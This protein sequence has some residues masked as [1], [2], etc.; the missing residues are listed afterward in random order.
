M[1]PLAAGEHEPSDSRFMDLI[2]SGGVDYVQLDIV[3]QGGIPTFRRIV[4]EIAKQG[5]RFAFHSWG[6]SLEVL[7]AAHLGICWPDSVVEWL[8]FPCYSTAGFE[9]MYPFPLADE[10]LKEPLEIDGGDLI[11][12]NR[13]GLGVEVDERGDRE[14]PVDSRAMVL[15]QDR[16]S[17]ADLGGVRRSRTAV[18]GSIVMALTLRSVAAWEILDS[19][20]N[21]TVAVEATLSN[22]VSGQAQVPSGASTGRHEALELRDGD[23]GWY[24]GKGVRR[25]VSNAATEIPLG[26]AVEPLSEFEALMLRADGTPDKSRL[27]ANAILGV[28]CAVARA[29]ANARGVRSGIC[30]KA[31]STQRRRC[32]PCRWSTFSRAGCMREDKSTSRISWPCLT[33]CRSTRKRFTPS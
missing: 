14:I 19:R 13:P 1:V 8:E 6:T 16:I 9:G 29:L 2:Q 20:G 33:D 7:A 22:G 15:F 23:S 5:L 30:S 32:S 26:V 28:S 21:P 17:S 3:G 24:G 27:G 10:I 31:S 18:V 25:A 12:P 11:V 4:P